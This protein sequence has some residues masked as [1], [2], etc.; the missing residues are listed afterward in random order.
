MTLFRRLPC[1]SL[2]I[3]AALGMPVAATAEPPPLLL[4]TTSPVTP[5]AFYLSVGGFAAVHRSK[6][7]EYGSLQTVSGAVFGP[8]RPLFKFGESITV[9]GGTATFGYSLDKSDPLGS[10]GTAPRIEI[11]FSLFRGSERDSSSPGNA[12]GAATCDFATIGKIGGPG[13]SGFGWLSLPPPV[14]P[15]GPN[16]GFLVDGSYRGRYWGGDGTLRYRTDFRVAPRFTISPSIGV[17][18]GAQVFKHELNINYRVEGTGT[19]LWDAQVQASLSSFHVG[20]DFGA[21]VTFIA[22]PRF[23]VHGGVT[24]AVL[25]RRANLKGRDC[26]TASGFP[27]PIVPGEAFG[28]ESSVDTSRSKLAFRVG[29]SAGATFKARAWLHFT[30]IGFGSWDSAVPGVARND[31]AFVNG[32]LV[33]SGP[34][35]IVFSGNWTYGGALVMTIPFR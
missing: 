19:P 30:V 35:R 17:L 23:T 20:P 11:G 5:G 31:T 7:F 9:G 25:Y 22:T 2:L 15:I 1:A 21:T 16:S 3:A 33:S 28:F 4:P 6:G 34:A 12:C 18:G 14:I 10:I 32:D 13:T 29:L 27:C 24:L 26:G 8:S